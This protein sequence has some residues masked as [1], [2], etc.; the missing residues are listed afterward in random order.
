ML[1]PT[2]RNLYQ[3]MSVQAEL[4]DPIAAHY[5][6]YNRNCRFLLVKTS[7]NIFEVDQISDNSY[8]LR[9]VKN[10]VTQAY[11]NIPQFGE[12]RVYKSGIR[13]TN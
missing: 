13:V 2:V 7:G 11:A 1:K 3:F 10:S 4:H 6:S 12:T 5:Y 8:V 9:I